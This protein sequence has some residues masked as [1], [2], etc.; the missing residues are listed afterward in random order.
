M[1]YLRAIFKVQARPGAYIILE[2][3]IN[4]GFFALLDRGA[5]I[6]RGLFSE[7]C[8]KLNIPVGIPWISVNRDDPMGAKIKTQ[9]NP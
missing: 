9:K 5:Y 4:G 1:L 6:W 2:G 8:S 3:Q 7:F